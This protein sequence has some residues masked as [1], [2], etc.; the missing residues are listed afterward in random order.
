MLPR[1]VGEGRPAQP[2]P[3]A[4][5]AGC[6]RS[7][8]PCRV[9]S[10]TRALWRKSPP[11]TRFRRN[12]PS[13][14]AESYPRTPGHRLRHH[15]RTS[16]TVAPGPLSIAGG[17]PHARPN[18][19]SLPRR[20]RA[21]K[22]ALR[23]SLAR[24]TLARR[25]TGAAFRPQV[26]R[27]G[28]AAGLAIDSRGRRRHT[29]RRF[30]VLVA[31]LI[32]GGGCAAS[33]INQWKRLRRGEYQGGPVGR[34]QHGS[35]RYEP[36]VRRVPAF[37]AAPSAAAPSSGR[38]CAGT[39]PT[40]SLVHSLHL[41]GRMQHPAHPSPAP[42]TARIVVIDGH[43]AVRQGL[44]TFLAADGYDLVFHP[45]AAGALAVIRQVQPAVA[46]IDLHLE[47]PSAGLEVVRALRA[48]P[49]TR[50]APAHRLVD[51][52]GRGAPGRRAGRGGGDGLS[53]YDAAATLRAAIAA[54]VAGPAARR[55]LVIEDD[56]DTRAVY[57]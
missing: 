30:A 53:K 29:G 11:E 9:T 23:A 8:R 55:V 6:V 7:N 27:G 15:E 48:D 38:G 17:D 22:G 42:A 25:G 41:P 35:P 3:G 39:G 57:E 45:R 5:L 32:N 12:D 56:R 52:S 43:P 26:R 49:A 44:A 18:L 54:A 34:F 10:A 33:L 20:T 2:A 46:I 21:C 31:S 28:D 37:G 13:C 16:A 51:R 1:N 40:A 19:L 4:R 14:T 47:V 24:Q 36:P 50:D